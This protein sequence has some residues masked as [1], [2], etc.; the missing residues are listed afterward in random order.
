M[1][2]VNNMAD[3]LLLSDFGILPMSH[4]KEEKNGAAK[5]SAKDETC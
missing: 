4:L 5:Q 1:T 3:D 2:H